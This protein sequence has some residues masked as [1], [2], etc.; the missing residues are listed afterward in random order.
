MVAHALRTLGSS[1]LHLDGA[2]CKERA[3]FISSWI[4]QILWKDKDEIFE[5]SLPYTE[6]EESDGCL[7]APGKNLLR[8]TYLKPMIR[9]AL[10]SLRD[11]VMW[12]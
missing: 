2:S 9:H 11:H 1:A 10:W 5:T 12:L 6:R 8:I 7:E 3:V 4:V